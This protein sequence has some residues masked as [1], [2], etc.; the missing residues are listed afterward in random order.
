M[1]IVMPILKTKN[2]TRGKLAERAGVSRNSV[3]DYLAGKRNL[4]SANRRAIA[5][6][7]GLNQKNSLIE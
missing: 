2:W 1:A 7:L 3:N 5:Q 6:E 4:S